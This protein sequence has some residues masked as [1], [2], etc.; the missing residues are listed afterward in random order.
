MAVNLDKPD[1]WKADVRASVDMYNEW[2]LNFAPDAFRKARIGAT[3]QVEFALSHT[4]N[5]RKIPWEVLHDQ[6]SLLSVL[7]MSCCPPIAVDRLAG[8]ADVP[9]TLIKSM[10]KSG[11]LPRRG[12][13]AA[14]LDVALAQMIEVIGK[15]IDPDIFHWLATKTK[16][17]T[18]DVHRAATIVADRLS[19]SLADPAIRNAQEARQL[20]VVG[21][22]LKARKYTQTTVPGDFRQMQPG[23][24]S[25]R[26]NVQ[27][28]KAGGETVNIPVDA[29]IMPKNAKPGQF[30]LLI[31]AKSAGDY[32][33]TNKRRKEEAQKINQLRATYNVKGADNIRFILFLCGYFDTGYLG[34]EAAEGIDWV[35]EHRTDDL[36]LFN[37]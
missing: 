29:V 30:P 28:D 35:W 22:W 7:R 2:F 25:F 26:L 8:L 4:D 32:T 13:V 3:K 9:S 37:L 18:A 16:P 20:A 15:L 34:Y 36:A 33:N 6:P 10:E 17:T 5:L 21:N 19:G 14:A 11:A 12:K 31:E 1:R 27:V 24:Y 23:T